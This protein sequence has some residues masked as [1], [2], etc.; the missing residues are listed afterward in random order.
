MIL[1]I[2]IIVTTMLIMYVKSNVDL[3]IVEVQLNRKLEPVQIKDLIDEMYAYDYANVYS[4]LI[5]GK[6]AKICDGNINILLKQYNYHDMKLTYTDKDVVVGEKYFEENMS[7]YRTLPE[8]MQ[9]GN[10]IYSINGV[11]LN[12]DDVIYRD[13]N[14]LTQCSVISQD[15]YIEKSSINGYVDNYTIK[16]V[17]DNSYTDIRKI[18]DY[19]DLY[20]VLRIIL[21]VLITIVLLILVGKLTK[22]LKNNLSL[23][24]NNYKSQRKSIYISQYLSQKNNIFNLLKIALMFIPIILIIVFCGVLLNDVLSTRVNINLNITSINNLDKIFNQYK[25]FLRYNMKNGFSY[26]EIIMLK[27][28]LCYIVLCVVA[29]LSIFKSLLKRAYRYVI[30]E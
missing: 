23:F 21:F 1:G 12:N 24:Y 16:T 20:N 26:Y 17:F 22:L 10:N 15:V 4:V 18:Y 6:P 3:N 30:G 5:N 29:F 2:F 25:E 13:L 7:K 27:I 9:I 14:L 19:Q 8:T 11:L 28:S